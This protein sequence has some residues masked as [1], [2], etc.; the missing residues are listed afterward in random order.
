MSELIEAFRE[1]KIIITVLGII[2]FMAFILPRIDRITDNP[3]EAIN[4][5]T[6]II[7]ETI[8]EIAGPKAISMEILLI[9]AGIIVSLI[10]G[11]I[12]YLRRL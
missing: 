12:T 3:N 5:G 7:E 9:F 1:V 8:D 2:G 6:E 11:A 10:A 4:I